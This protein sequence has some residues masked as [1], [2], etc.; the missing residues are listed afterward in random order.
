MLPPPLPAKKPSAVIIEWDPAR[1]AWADVNH[2]HPLLSPQQYAESSR[3]GFIGIK[4][5]QDGRPADMGVQMV[6]AAEQHGLA[7]VG[8]QYGTRDPDGFLKLFPPREGR[9]ACLDFE[10]DSATAGDIGAA[11]AFTRRVG[12]AYGRPP[13]F[14]AGGVE[15]RRAGEPE[16]TAMSQLPAWCAQYGPHLRVMH[17]LGRPVA[18]QYSDGLA[19]PETGARW[20]AGV[21]GTCDMS[22]FLVPLDEIRDMADIERTV[23]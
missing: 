22:V 8:Y 5:S 21:K 6:Q 23:A 7:V 9:I 15:W 16:G 17:G 18:W 1:L 14:Y 19:G 4:I 10:G 3:C 11:E 12:E 13:W 20:H 2:Y